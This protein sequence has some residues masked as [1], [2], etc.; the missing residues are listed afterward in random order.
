LSRTFEG[1]SGGRNPALCGPFFKGQAAAQLDWVKGFHDFRH[2]RATQ[3]LING[4]DVRTVQELLGHSN[5]NTTMRYV[6]YI[7]Q[8]ASDAIQR[9]QKREMEAITGR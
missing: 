5:I 9:A 8:H 3:W 6:H 1:A 4:V 7:Q 2:F